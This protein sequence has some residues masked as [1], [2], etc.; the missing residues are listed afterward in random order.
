MD[1]LQEYIS[2][3]TKQMNNNIEREIIRFLQEEGYDVDESITGQQVSALIKQFEA[4]G[5]RLRVEIFTKMSG[6]LTATMVVIPFFEPLDV[7]ITR[8]EIY[9]MFRLASQGYQI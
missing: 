5:K 1:V 8:T 7:V 9:R 3:C 6:N 4:E 2:E